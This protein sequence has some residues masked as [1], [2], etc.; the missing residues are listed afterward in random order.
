MPQ[1][2]FERERHGDRPNLS[3]TSLCVTSSASRYHSNF[4]LDSKPST[5]KIREA[6]LDHPA[7]TLA[8][9]EIRAL[10]K[11]LQVLLCLSF[12]RVIFGDSSRSEC[13]EWTSCTFFRKVFLDPLMGGSAIIQSAHYNNDRDHVSVVRCAESLELLKSRRLLV[14]P[15]I[16][17]EKIR[18]GPPLDT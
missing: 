11:L 15:S 12:H 1:I 6:F 18:L 17:Y 7:S 9:N 10:D 13:R 16:I 4:K 8:S 2:L 14:L 5:Q 3:T